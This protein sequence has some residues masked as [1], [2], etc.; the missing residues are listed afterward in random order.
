[1]NDLTPKIATYTIETLLAGENNAAKEFDLFR[2][3]YF[4]RDIEHLKMPHRHYFFT[5][6][7]VTGG[8]G[9]HDID[10]TTYALQPNR[11]FLIAPGQVHAWNELNHVTGFVL[12]F[13]DNFVALSKGRKLLANWPLFRA[14]QMCYVDIASDDLA[15]WVEQFET[16]EAEIKI[17][18][19]YT[20]DAIFYSI[21][22]LLVRASRQYEVVNSGYSSSQDLLFQFQELIEQNFTTLKTPKE[23]A[24]RL[25]ITPN[26]LNSFCKKHSGRSAGELIRQRIILEAKRWLAHTQL[27]VAQ[28]AYQLNFEDNS[29]FGRFF[30]KYTKTTPDQF[31]ASQKK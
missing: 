21:G 29:Y 30:K 11:L 12:L 9:N 25:H 17:S 8:S 27:P 18:D 5:F 6:I 15:K 16:M 3:E 28:V 13:T 23:Y 20:R 31:R 7:L 2:F 14:G 19:D 24:I 22:N 1:M 10:F 26:Y 4:A